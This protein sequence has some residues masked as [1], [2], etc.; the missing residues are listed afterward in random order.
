MPEGWYDDPF[1][2]H[3]QRYWTGTTWTKDTRPRPPEP[4]P[5]ALT[6]APLD[7]F[8]GA[9]MPASPPPV[10][11]TSG[12]PAPAWNAPPAGG[13]PVVIRDYLILSILALIFCFWPLAI[14]AVY[15]A[16]RTNSAKRSGQWDQAL[17]YSERT[18]LFLLLSVVG[19]LLVA[20]YL[21]WVVLSE[22]SGSLGL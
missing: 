1:T 18:R 7:P 19:G 12:T 22:G 2:D 5:A 8:T 9:P 11:S 15:F 14:P 4:S 16:V 3:L 10:P 13:A 21:T 6:D 20:A 17:K